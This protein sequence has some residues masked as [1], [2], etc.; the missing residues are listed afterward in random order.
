[1]K[2]SDLPI[3]AVF[4]ENSTGEYCLK[5]SS[6]MSTVYDFSKKEVFTYNAGRTIDFEFP[7]DHEV[8][9]PE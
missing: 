7:P 1:M 2:F 9:L 6:T 4:F 3:G 5:V 8:E